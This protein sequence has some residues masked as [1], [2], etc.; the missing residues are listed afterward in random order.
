[1]KVPEEQL[2]KWTDHLNAGDRATVRAGELTT[3]QFHEASMGVVRALHEV[4]DVFVQSGQFKETWDG[5]SFILHPFSTQVFRKAGKVDAE[6]SLSADLEG[7]TLHTWLRCDLL[8]QVGDTFWRSLLTLSECGDLTVEQSGGSAAPVSAGPNSFRSKSVVYRMM[9][10]H[11]FSALA[12]DGTEPTFDFTI[13]W[14]KEAIPIE[15]VLAKG[16][17]AFRIM[18]GL[19]YALWKARESKRKEAV[20]RTGQP[21]G[22]TG[23]ASGTGRTAK[24]IS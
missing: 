23:A 2:K 12:A 4:Q 22:A 24:S 8:G 10:E 6:F 17:E 18:Y 5:G 21:H 20:R 13:G 9:R 16:S 3:E 14:K 19:H 1:M 15:G 7:I 11:L